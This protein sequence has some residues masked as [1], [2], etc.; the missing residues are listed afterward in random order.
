MSLE[1]TILVVEDETHLAEGLLFNLRAE[2]YD[3]QL[4]ADGETALAI[5]ASTRIDAI[6]LDVMLPGRDGFSVAA[7]LRARQ[8]Y[9]PILMLTARGRPEDILLGFAA[10]A[11]DYL[12]KPF[13]LSVLLARLRGLLRRMAW[14]RPELS[15]IPGDDAPA[16]ESP[17]S[18]CFA[19]RNV[20]FDSTSS[21]P[22]P[23]S[24][25]A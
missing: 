10:G 12:A 3:A 6:I 7:E 8:N 1:T 5:I 23:T 9:L 21:S 17:S 14:P 16:A 22:A 25:C 18:F 15:P 2:G 11:D 13:D 19:G 24:S 20:D 4:A